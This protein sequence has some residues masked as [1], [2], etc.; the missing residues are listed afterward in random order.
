M[1]QPPYEGE[2]QIRAHIIPFPRAFLSLN[3]QA[4]PEGGKFLCRHVGENWKACHTRYSH[5]TW[6]SPLLCDGLPD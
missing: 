4:G 5:D 6:V 1:N 2:L 3:A